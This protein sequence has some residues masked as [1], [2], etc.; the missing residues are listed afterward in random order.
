MLRKTEFQV[1]LA[2][3]ALGL[4]LLVAAIPLGVSS[5]SN[6]PKLVLSPLFWPQILAGVLIFI[7]VLLLVSVPVAPEPEPESSIF[8]IEGGV[9]RL[10]LMAAAMVAYFVLIPLIGMVWASMLAFAATAVLVKT[11][12]PLAAVVAAIVVP[13]ALYAFFAHVAGVAVPQGEF[14]RLP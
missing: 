8:R 12:H 2:A 5:P 1:G 4:F 3:V 7:G 11:R 6:V 10:A 9:V 14:V 13:L